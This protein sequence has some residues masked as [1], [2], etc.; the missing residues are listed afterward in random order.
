MMKILKKILVLFLVGVI[1]FSSYN[2]FLIYKQNQ[3]EK[4]A[5]DAINSAIDKKDDLIR[6]S[7]ITIPKL[8]LQTITHDELM[9]MKEVNKDVVGYL[10]FDSG[11]ISEPVVQTTNNEYYLYHDIN[12]GYNDFGTVL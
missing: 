4:K 8:S 11:L 7:N 2:L 10:Q 5:L 1:G 6:E 12:H 3:D 9:K